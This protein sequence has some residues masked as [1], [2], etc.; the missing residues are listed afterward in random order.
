M[1]RSC[2]GSSAREQG[3]KVW[4]RTFTTKP[5]QRL[6][7]ETITEPC[8]QGDWDH[9]QLY[10][11]TAPWWW[12]DEGRSTQGACLHGW[13]VVR[14]RGGRSVLKSSPG[15]TSYREGEREGKFPSWGGVEGGQTWATGSPEAPAL[16]YF[17]SPP[18]WD[19]WG[20]GWVL[21]FLKTTK[22]EKQKT[23][24]SLFLTPPEGTKVGS[25]QHHLE[26]KL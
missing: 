23:F 12:L 20:F 10:F 15:R 21:S 22:A 6:L 1:L 5:G 2:V 24:P 7:K 17:F 9:A 14:W 11:F 13:F 19:T 25:T 3:R 16:A 8:V 26:Y 4:S 18:S